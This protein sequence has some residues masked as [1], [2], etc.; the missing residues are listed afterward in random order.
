MTTDKKKKILILE[1]YARVSGG[2]RVI[3]SIIE[4][5]SDTYEFHVVVPESGELTGELNRLGIA[6]T[7][8]PV[9]YYGIGKKS[10]FDIVRYAFKSPI[11]ARKLTRLI[12]A[13][14]PDMVYANGARTFVWGT[15]AC[16]LTQTPMVWHIHSIF[17]RGITR[18]LCLMF[19]RMRAVKKIIAVSDAAARPLGPLKGKMSIMRNAVNCSLFFP[20]DSPSGALRG[21]L[22][23]HNTIVIGMVGLLI[24]WKGVD[25]FLKAAALVRQQRPDVHFVVVGDVLCRADAGYRVRLEKL[26]ARLGLRDAVTFTGQRRDIPQVMRDLDIFVLASKKPDPCPTSLLQAMACGAAVVAPDSGGAV[27]IIDHG[28]T[29]LLFREGS[30]DGL[31]QAILSLIGDPKKRTA[32]QQAA[33]AAVRE[34]Y[35]QDEYMRAID[36]LIRAIS[37]ERD[38]YAAHNPSWHL[39]DSAWKA[40][41]I[42]RVIPAEIIGSLASPVMIVDIGCGAGRILKLVAGAFQEQGLEVIAE[43]FDVSPVPLRAARGEYPGAQFHCEAFD[44][45]RY[46]GNNRH[47]AFSLLIDILEHLDDPQTLLKEVGQ[48]SDY[49]I[50]HIPLEDNLMVNSRGL[51]KRF[52]RTVK[53]V[54]FYDEK[55]ARSLFTDSGFT[56][57]NS[58]YTCLDYDADYRFESAG[59]RILLQPLRRFFFGRF[60]RFTARV[61]GNVS[62]LALLKKS[63]PSRSGEG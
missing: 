35:G 22:T 14:K 51:R 27:E 55:T 58:M 17:A 29:G 56:V 44:K 34:R 42:L 62:L 40:R 7:V 49:V 28:S 20:Q 39:E 15:I 24:E 61:L 32:I 21:S 16:S 18:R 60:P 26:A 59:R 41:K 5:L 2:Q 63:A 4:C 30:V 1:Q 19:G 8:F 31:A 54:A 33:A 50:C 38:D 37:D 3:L 6:Y 45:A 11:L 57:I 53:H 48:V 23:A 9:G 52:K 13:L 25:I 36:T 46:S 43:G 47:P 10:F 12:S